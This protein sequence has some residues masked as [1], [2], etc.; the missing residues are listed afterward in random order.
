MNWVLD[1][2]EREREREKKGERERIRLKGHDSATRGKKK[3]EGASNAIFTLHVLWETSQD[4]TFYFIKL[5]WRF[6]SNSW[7]C[8]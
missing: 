7:S 4:L 8:L 3:K 2:R 6:P 5:K 1:L